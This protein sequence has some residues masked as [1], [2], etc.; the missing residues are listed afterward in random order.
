MLEGMRLPVSNL[1]MF[2]LGACTASALGAHAGAPTT[3]PTAPASTRAASP[4]PS[5]VVR[6]SEVQ[7]R[8]SPAGTAVITPLLRGPH[9][10]VSRLE[11]AAG[12][13]IPEHVDATDESIV[14]L[15]GSGTLTI[16]GEAHAIAA[17]SAV[18]M[19]GGATVSYVNGA[20][21]MTV[22]Q[23]FSPPGPERK[24]DAWAP[25]DD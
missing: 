25:V 2:L 9:A 16:D 7:R 4:S 23:V 19:P 10:F 8:R 3:E 14:V 24:Y 6:A 22:I 18:L 21:P 15:E 11:L 5:A 13:T 17:G 12:A 20:A 1:A